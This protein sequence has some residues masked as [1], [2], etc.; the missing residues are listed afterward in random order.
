MWEIYHQKTKKI[1]FFGIFLAFFKNK[2]AL[3]FAVT[4]LEPVRLLFPTDYAHA[5]YYGRLL[6]EA[7]DQPEAMLAF[8][9]AV[10]SRTKDHVIY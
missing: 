1:H 7:G 4:T 9:R 5:N 2:P 10:H 8:L 6:R 3:A